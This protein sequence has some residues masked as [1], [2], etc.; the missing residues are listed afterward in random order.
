MVDLTYDRGIML[1]YG[2]D[3][4]T[5]VVLEVVNG[6]GIG[7]QFLSGTFDNDKYKNFFGRISQD[8][9]DHFRIGAMGYWGKEE[10]EVYNSNEEGYLYPQNETWMLGADATIRFDPLEL[11][12]QYVERNDDNAYFL[13]EYNIGEIEDTEIRTRGGFAELIFR[14]DGDESNWYTVALYNYIDVDDHELDRESRDINSL[15]IHFGYLLRRNIR[16]VTEY[17]QNFTNEYGTIG[18]G[19]VTAF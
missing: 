8:A 18:L 9:G 6:S 3:T 1:G 11:N 12:L 5:D 17:S 10:H 2:F 7:E 15:A 13:H 19:F 14:P 4:G 16:L